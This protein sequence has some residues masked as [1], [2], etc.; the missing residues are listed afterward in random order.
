M[1][2]ERLG[3][4]ARKPGPRIGLALGGGS[5]RGLAHVVMLEAFDELGVKPAIIAGT[6]MGAICGAAYAAGQFGRRAARGVPGRIRPAA[7]SSCKRLAG[8]LRGGSPLWTMRA[9]SVDNVTLFEMLLP[10]AMRCSFDALKIPFLAIAADFYAI[11]QVVLDKGPL[12]PALA[13]SSALPQPRPAG[14]ASTVAC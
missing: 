2:G 8:K 11:E 7:G 6:S 9:P 13:A 10:D 3:T 5:A 4:G 12:I 14:G 1:T